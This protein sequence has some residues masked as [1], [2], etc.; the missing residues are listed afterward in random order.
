MSSCVNLAFCAGLGLV[1]WSR[2]WRGRLCRVFTGFKP[3]II[4]FE[5]TVCRSLYMLNLIDI[6]V[7]YVSQRTTEMD[8]SYFLPFTHQTEENSCMHI[9]SLF[10]M[11][12]A[13]TPVNNT[14]EF[15]R[16]ERMNSQKRESEE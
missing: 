3:P 9:S 5:L 14:P 16:D 7:G 13:N 8:G 15:I 10:W 4:E 1:H 12:R 2:C 11:V 6:N